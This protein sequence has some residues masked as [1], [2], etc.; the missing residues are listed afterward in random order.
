MNIDCWK[1]RCAHFSCRF[2]RHANQIS[3][4]SN[5]TSI[6]LLTDFTF[7]IYPGIYLIRY[8]RS[9]FF[10]CTNCQTL[11]WKRH[12]AKISINISK[13]W[14]ASHV[15]SVASCSCYSHAAID[16]VLADAVTATALAAIAAPTE[17]REC[18]KSIFHIAHHTPNMSHKWFIYSFPND[19]NTNTHGCVMR[20]KRRT[21]EHMQTGKQV[22]CAQ[23]FSNFSCRQQTNGKLLRGNC[24]LIRSGTRLCTFF[25]NEIECNLILGLITFVRRRS[26]PDCLSDKREL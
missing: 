24:W 6:S 9:A 4:S 7:I 17:S 13:L 22:R 11:S 16:I 1:M 26:R 14:T 19:T 23:I 20:T 25:R 3:T 2:F 15:K 18:D 21:H 10:A 12:R 8:C 5:F